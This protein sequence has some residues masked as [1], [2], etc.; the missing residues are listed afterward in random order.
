MPETWLMEARVLEEAREN[1]RDRPRL[2]AVHPEPSV[3][4]PAHTATVYRFPTYRRRLAENAARRRS[5]RRQRLLNVVRWSFGTLALGVFLAANQ[6][7]ILYDQLA[8]A[9]GVFLAFGLLMTSERL[10][11]R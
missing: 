11:R 10:F 4:A 2:R 6:A 5:R 3:P 1:L 8:G 9:A 7:A